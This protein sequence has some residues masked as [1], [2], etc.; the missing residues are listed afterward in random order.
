MLG[1]DLTIGVNREHV[2]VKKIE[3]IVR[4][5]LFL[6]KRVN[7]NGD[8]HRRERERERERDREIER[9]R[10]GEGGREGGRE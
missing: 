1:C 2:K 9:E 4:L 5:V 8:D 3:H 7:I 6:H 10:G